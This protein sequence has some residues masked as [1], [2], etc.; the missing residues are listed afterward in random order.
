M[1]S[2]HTSC[3]TLTVGAQSLLLGVVLVVA[4]VRRGPGAED[5][6]L[7][8]PLHHDRTNA[9]FQKKELHDSE[10]IGAVFKYVLI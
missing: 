10:Q 8:Q 1:R 6:A 7:D 3:S 4:A 9:D 2:K 5:E